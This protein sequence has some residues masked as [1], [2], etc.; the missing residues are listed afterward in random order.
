MEVQEIL[1]S[2]RASECALSRRLN[3]PEMHGGIM[4]RTTITPAK[5]G[6]IETDNITGPYLGA[7]KQNKE[8]HSLIG[9]LD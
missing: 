6:F 1:L 2:A 8:K 4:L 3:T 7:L 9:F 5:A